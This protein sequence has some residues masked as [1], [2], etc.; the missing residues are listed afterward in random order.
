MIK[1]VSVYEHKF[2]PEMLYHLLRERTPE[3]SISHKEMPKK[4]DHIRF[5]ESKPYP[6]W[7]LIMEGSE[8][9][10]S[11]Y[12]TNL[13]E[14]GIFIFKAHKGKG[15][16]KMAI[17]KVLELHPGP[18]LANVNPQNEPSKS[19]FESLGGKVVQHTYRIEP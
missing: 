16:A 11:V 12:L 4:D 7:Y 8:I 6:F 2:A 17:Q 5:I 18:Y 9:V 14:I 15:L 3:Q 1:L 19:L 10:G 13:R